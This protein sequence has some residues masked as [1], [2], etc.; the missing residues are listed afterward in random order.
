MKL[1]AVIVNYRTADTTL[2]ALEKLLAELAGLDAEVTVVDNDS[3]DGSFERLR[4]G[5][6]ARGWSGSVNVVLAARN[7]G[8]GYGNN[9]AIRPALSSAEPPSF[10][11]LINPDAF[12]DPGAVSALLAVMQAHPEVG[13][14]GSELYGSDGKPHISAFRFPNL[15]GELEAGLRLGLATRALAR[16]VVAAPMPARSS[17]VDWVS[18]ACMMI[19]R[20]VFE[21]IGLFD[22]RYF[23]YFEETDLCRRARAAGF[24]VF[25]VRES[26]AQHIGGKA[27]GAVS[28]EHPVPAHFFASRRQ[29]YLKN[30]GRRYLLGANALWAMGFSLWRVRRVLQRKPDRDPPHLL[31]DFFRQSFVAPLLLL[32]TV[33]AMAGCASERPYV[34]AR[35]VPAARADF[36]ERI[37]VGDKIYVLVRG[38]EQLS[39][40]FEVKADGSYV[41]P[42]VGAVR[43]AEASPR[44]AALIIAQRLRGVL[45]TPQ[46]SVAILSPRPPAISVL[47]EVSEPGHFEV[48]R[49]EGVLGALARAGGLTEFADRDGIFVVRTQPKHERIRFRYDDLVG[50][51]PRSV[52]FKLR[53][54][55]VVVVE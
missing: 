33:V 27:T 43:V 32:L 47:G 37:Q 3:Q 13:I 52:T 53:D 21:R 30:H 35:D 50:A 7:G 40:E 19:R 14:A 9:L 12:L 39:G 51:E 44:D 11:L 4:A 54:G 55:D 24:S 42:I 41:Q 2:R 10:V 22:E 29:Y 17:A 8:F 20:E 16:W 45:Q 31:R 36:G 46:V 15:L 48:T 26:R 1:L 34:W 49:N 6:E 23:L 25:T 38:Q 28:A 5:V 18:G